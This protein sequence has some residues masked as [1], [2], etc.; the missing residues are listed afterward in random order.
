[1]RNLL[2][3]N[4]PASK[5]PVWLGKAVGTGLSARPANAMTLSSLV[6]QPYHLSNVG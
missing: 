3:P 6:M 2:F 1:M 4:G 5:C